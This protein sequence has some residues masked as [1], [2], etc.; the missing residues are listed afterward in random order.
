MPK[1]SCDY[2]RWHDF[3]ALRSRVEA[4]R[5]LRLAETN[6]CKW[7]RVFGTLPELELIEFSNIPSCHL[8][9]D[10]MFELC[11]VIQTTLDRPDIDGVVVTHGTDA[12]EET[13]YMADLWVES[14]KPRGLHRSHAQQLRDRGGRAAKHPRSVRV[15]TCSDARGL[16]TLVVFNG[17][18]LAARDTIKMHTSN[19]DAFRSPMLG[20]MGNVDDDAVVIFRRSLVRQPSRRKSMR[21]RS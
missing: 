1:I 12:L 20:P 6:C 18:V 17:R 2:Y 4:A 13:A 7:C 9:P 15:A 5:C 3:D 11:H 10:T 21:N 19:L 8:T 14:E 16:G